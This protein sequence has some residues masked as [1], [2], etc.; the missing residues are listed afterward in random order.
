MIKSSKRSALCDKINRMPFRAMYQNLLDG[1]YEQMKEQS[2]RAYDPYADSRLLANQSFLFI[3]SGDTSWA[4]GAWKTAERI[5]SDVLIVKGISLNARRWRINT[6]EFDEL[7]KTVNG[8][9]LIAPN[10]ASMRVQFLCPDYALKL[11]MVCYGGDTESHNPEIWYKNKSY[12]FSKYID[13]FC[14]VQVTTVITL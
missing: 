2:V 13:A 9:Q 7:R 4:E 10:G 5:L 6:P 3:L 14:E 8:Y 11:K 12:A 1:A